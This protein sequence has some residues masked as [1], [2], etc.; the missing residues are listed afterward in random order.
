MRPEALIKPGFSC[1]IYRL[2]KGYTRP[3]DEYM[4]PFHGYLGTIQGHM[5]PF[6]GSA[7]A[8]SARH[9]SRVGDI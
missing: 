1:R 5:S 6:A 3:F 4:R 8:S 7:Q 2:F 9:F